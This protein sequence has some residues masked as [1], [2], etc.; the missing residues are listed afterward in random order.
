MSVYTEKD[1][2]HF[3]DNIDTV[4]E[5]V[6]KKKLELFEPTGDEIQ[7]VNEII[8]KFIKDNK[9]KIYGGLAMHMLINE[10]KPDSKDII[11]PNNKA[12]LADI[13]FYSTEPIIDLIKLCNILHEKGFKNVIG[14][15]GQHAETY[16]IFVNYGAFCDISYVPKNIYNRMPFK[17]INGIM[18]IHP[19]WMAIDYFRM[20]AD[21]LISYW[22][23]EKGFKRFIKLQKYY[24]LPKSDKQITIKYPTNDSTQLSQL[25]NTFQ[26]YLVGK[27]TMITIGF[28]AYNHF[29][30]E[31]K[32]LESKEKFAKKYKYLDIPYFEV[33]STN[34]RDDTLNLVSKLKNDH[35]SLANDITIEEH[36]PFF[37][38]FGYHSY[39]YYKDIVIG[40]IYTNNKLCV[41]FKSVSADKFINN[42]I[43]KNTGNMLIG[44]FTT[45]LYYTLSTVMKVRTDGDDLTKDLY[46]TLLSH[47]IEMRG[48]YFAKE[49][50]NIFSNSL[51]QDFVVECKGVTIM[52]DREKR[53]IIE[54]RKKKG[55]P[56]NFK[57]EPA[58]GVKAP[59]SNY[60]FANSSGNK[61][62]NSKNL[63]LGPQVVEEDIDEDL[64]EDN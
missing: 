60:R 53:L 24:P 31:S 14:T 28:Y 6:E 10:Q 33:I 41:P 36:Y 5:E 3:K 27:D 19:N 18:C 40:V 48:F 2:D 46:F 55:K 23:I 15:E 59:E 39:I 16:K 52:P 9:R 61:I 37:M 25:I 64:E 30:Q 8:M 42:K 1:F 56:Y 38:Y 20:L 51:F 21:P 7:K 26:N 50:K 17:E 62:V 11:Y 22:R 47:L 4:M 57:Y 58:N 43:E 45:T 34:Y 13:D 32:M 12:K 49:K 35:P 63:K 54:S 29:L 44:T